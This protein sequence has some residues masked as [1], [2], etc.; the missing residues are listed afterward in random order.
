MA[1]DTSLTFSLYGK[2]VSAT[3]SLQDVGKEAQT[4]G[5]HFGKIGEIA[6]GLGL[7]KG[8]EVLGQKVLDFGKESINAFQNVGKEVKLLQ[9]YTGD[10]AEE[11]SKL[12]F[13]AEESGVS[14]D[15]L[16]LALG[17]M[18]KAASTVAGE[19]K[20]EA[21]GVSVKDTSGHMRSASDIFTDVATKL[22]TMHNGVEKTNAIMQIFGRSGMDLAPLL[23]QGAAGIAK[24]KEEAQKFGLVLTQ[25]NLDAVKKNTMAHRELHAAVEGM[26]VQ[27][28]QYLYPAL[29]AITK[30]FSEIVPIIAQGLKPAFK[31]LGEILDPVVSLIQNGTKYIV[32]LM[33]N[34]KIGKTVT[35]E[36]GGAFDAFRPFIENIEK[37]F[38]TLHKFA[39]S[40]L[41]PIFKD[42]AGFI[43]N[44][45]IQY[46]KTIAH[47]V[48]DDII[49]AFETIVNKVS[50]ALQPAIESVT[51]ALSDHKDQFEAVLHAIEF[52]VHIVDTLKNGLLKFV[53][54]IIKDI[55]PFIGDVLGFAFKTVGNIISDAINF[56]GDFIK[57]IQK[58]VS[59]G[60]SIASEIGSIFSG[61]ASTIKSVIN[62]IIDLVNTAIGALNSLKIHIP[63]TNINI[64]V[65][66]PKIPKLAEGGIVNSP[67]L[68][69]IGEAGSEAVIPLNKMGSMGGGMSVVVNVQGSVISEGQL[70]TKVRDGLA[71]TMRRK[72]VSTAVLGL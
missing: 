41:L 62:N 42:V 9:R 10:S 29:T 60:K 16:A 66:I 34:F 53:G 43:K 19:K 70:I 14:T 52:V 17:K 25:D 20:F 64:G 49:P 3:K 32:D 54:A 31:V 55:A 37:S 46:F 24:F 18:S 39:D 57:A 21:I 40:F 45:F 22:G 12:R 33:S 58:I 30:A 15:T 13:A 51:K 23:N 72:G 38:K 48:M 71:Q 69:L 44:E 63:G 27:L 68:A 65:D 35:N 2:D 67:T 8:V 56:I 28:G 26:Q 50:K 5:G 1:N 59:V 47:V 7:A 11:M 6:A 36:L 61:I 4:A